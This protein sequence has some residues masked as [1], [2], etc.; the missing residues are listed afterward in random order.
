MMQS[1]YLQRLVKK[2]SILSMI[3]MAQNLVFAQFSPSHSSNLVNYVPGAQIVISIM[4]DG[5]NPED[6]SMQVNL[7]GLPGTWVTGNEVINPAPL[8]KGVNGLTGVYELAYQAFGAVTVPGPNDTITI[9]MNVPA[10]FE[11]VV[12]LNMEIIR[13]TNDPVQSISNP[14][15]INPPPPCT[16][17]SP[18]P[19]DGSRSEQDPL[20]ISNEVT[21]GQTI[22]FSADVA[23]SDG[24]NLAS[25]TFFVATTTFNEQSGL[26]EKDDGD[27]ANWPTPQEIDF[28]GPGSQTES[29]NGNDHLFTW[30]PIAGDAAGTRTVTW[31]VP[32]SLLNKGT[33]LVDRV[34]LVGIRGTQA[35]GAQCSQMWAV[36]VNPINQVPVFVSESSMFNGS[37]IDDPD[38]DNMVEVSTNENEVNTFEIDVNDPDVIDVLSVNWRIDGGDSVE[39]DPIPAETQKPASVDL[40]RTF[41]FGTV[42]HPEQSKEI[43]VTATL[44]DGVAATDF[45]WKVTV[46][47]SNQLPVIDTNSVAVDLAPETPKTNDDLICTLT[48]DATDGDPEDSTLQYRFIWL[49][50]DTEIRNELLE[51][52]SDTLPAGLT[53]KNKT[54]TCRVN[55]ED[56]IGGESETKLPV[57][58]EIE[59]SP[60]V[61]VS[62]TIVVS[63][64]IEKQIQLQA[65]DEDGDDL[66]FNLL[67]DIIRTQ[68]GQ[69]QGPEYNLMATLSPRQETPPVPTNQSS[70]TGETTSLV[71][72]TAANTLTYSIDFR[73]LSSD[74]TLAHIHGPNG[75]GSPAGVMFNFNP[76][77]GIRE[78]TLSGTWNYVDSPAAN[79]LTEAEVE[80][81]LLN[82]NTYINIHT[83][84]FGPGELRGQIG[85]SLLD[86]SL[87]VNGDGS[88][89]F[90]PGTGREPDFYSF[91]YNVDDGSDDSEINVITLQILDNQAPLCGRAIPGEEITAVPEGSTQQFTIRASDNDGTIASIIWK[92]NGVDARTVNPE[93]ATFEDVFE[94]TVPFDVVSHP[95][96]EGQ[97]E[98]TVEVTDD[99][100]VTAVQNTELSPCNWI[101]PVMDSNQAPNVGS[102]ELKVLNNGDPVTGSRLECTVIPAGD[103]DDIAEGRIEPLQFIHRF[104]MNGD[105]EN[106]IITD[107][108]ETVTRSIASTK[109]NEK[110]TCKVDILDI[111]YDEGTDAS[112]A[113]PLSNEIEIQNS[114]PECGTEN[115]TVAEDTILNGQ[116]SGTDIDAAAEVDTLTFTKTSDPANGTLENF[117]AATGTF[118]YTPNQDFDETDSF[119]FT[120]SDGTE[121]EDPV[122][123][124][125]NIVV[126]PVNDQPTAKDIAEEVKANKDDLPK[127]NSVDL[128]LVGDDIEDAPETLNFRIEQR[129]LVRIE[130]LEGSTTPL[131]PGVWA[132]H[133]QEDPIFTEGVAD[134]GQGLEALAEDGN[135]DQLGAAL[136]NQSGV[137]SSNIFN[138]PVGATAPGP[139]LPGNAYEF[140]VTA[141]PSDRLTFATMFVQSNDLFFA[142]NGAGI[143]FFNENIPTNGD[144]TNQV[145]LWDAGTE[146]NEE[147][148]NGA[149]QPPASGGEEENGTVQLVSNV[150]DG[151]TYPAVDATLR[152][153]ITPITD[154]SKG[155][156]ETNGGTVVEA[157]DLITNADIPLKFFPLPGEKDTAE[158]QYV[159]IDSENSKSVPAL[160]M[161]KI[162]SGPPWFPELSFDPIEGAASYNV[163]I[164]QNSDLVNPTFE[165]NVKTTE[166]LPR[167]YFSSGFHGFIPGEY[168]WFYQ[169]VDENGT[170]GE[171]VPGNPLDPGSVG[172][173]L[174]VDEYGDPNEPDFP[175]D[176]EDIVSQGE[177]DPDRELNFTVDNSSGYVVRVIRRDSPGESE[178]DRR[179][180]QQFFSPDNNG[181]IPIDETSK[182]VVRLNQSGNYEFSVIGFNPKSINEMGELMLP[183]EFP[184]F[185]SSPLSQDQFISSPSEPLDELNLLTPVPD[186]EITTIGSES[187]TCLSWTSVPGASN[188]FLNVSSS[189]PGVGVIIGQENV[190]TETSICI[191]ASREGNFVIFEND[192]GVSSSKRRAIANQ[193]QITFTWWVAALD[194]GVEDRGENFAGLSYSVPQKFTLIFP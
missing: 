28:N 65:S 123:C 161:I 52:K 109:K 33:D 29:V 146:V 142:P 164:F 41:D 61:G 4:L 5:A 44:D 102:V 162:K 191:K 121:G 103:P 90:N 138:T 99:Q 106:A 183:E 116:V 91:T 8:I 190:G 145:A 147:P 53:S 125:L 137:D 1:T 186:A 110:W 113:T 94:Y 30:T 122:T 179:E 11:D 126:G 49:D 23:A 144:V 168:Q 93:V 150:N 70:A 57:S 169:S 18:S 27:T 118:N 50:G 35:N 58:T 77:T 139:L 156:I 151:F 37:P 114:L 21:A 6:R 112:T 128:D 165:T 31:G 148:G 124:T 160:I 97:V 141:F 12:P 66:T 104:I 159:S 182:Q 63:T 140:T 55:A 14:V 180:F 83:A 62:E 163:K 69:D 60:P 98:I 154:L 173:P 192:L 7:P 74:L 59:N 10:D 172:N 16:V 149:N 20:N 153:T 120:I 25:S 42:V 47:D 78:G 32:E 13:E 178:V 45:V 22:T 134:R 15:T 157:G 101:Q 84:N 158:I 175:S 92:V 100:G 189:D 81:A 36:R 85:H 184:N 48:G 72:N 38:N 129:F 174:T 43:M 193:T 51:A 79:G 167:N 26:W 82:G 34:F 187:T 188:Y 111:P 177:G 76:T 71:L 181:D 166:V 9:T 135:P 155:I 96:K 54:I 130:N 67:T 73:D 19:A 40:Q 127:E 2:I 108:R 170:P 64:G 105:E 88:A 115:L 89:T 131:A 24:E 56:Q 136:P 46:N 17:S 119:E 87:S 133:H 132:V 75:V 143:A 80:E 86:A 185:P 117:D 176:G 3:L 152:V 171:F 194:S 39:T 107:A 68:N 95:Q